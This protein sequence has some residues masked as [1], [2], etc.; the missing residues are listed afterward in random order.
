MKQSKFKIGILSLFLSLGL[1]F[2]NC[3]RDDDNLLANEPITVEDAEVVADV[4]EVSEGVIDLVDQL[5]VE[6]GMMGNRMEF[7]SFFPNCGTR[8][9]KWD[10]AELMKT[11]TLDFGNGCTLHNGNFVKGKITIVF[12]KNRDLLSHTITVKYENFYFNSKKVEGT[13]SVERLASNANGNPQSKVKINLKITFADGLYV[14]RESVKVREMIAGKAT[15]GVWNDN[16]F[17]ITGNWTTV[18]K[19]GTIHKGEIITPLR[20]EMTC[21]FIVSGTIKV[22]KNNKTGTIDFGN[23]ACDHFA[24][25]TSE[26]SYVKEIILGKR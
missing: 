17:L 8:T 22:V 3:Q 4:D 24:T 23:G 25:F 12:N 1:V 2:T 9:I 26:N 21:K 6:D 10:T 14:E 15:L 5:Y 18:F 7:T 16:V 20:R 19:N 11:V 13:T